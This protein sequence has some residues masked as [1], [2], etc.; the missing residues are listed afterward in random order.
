MR[1][2]VFSAAGELAY[3]AGRMAFD[4]GEHEAAWRDFRT[5]VHLADEAG[6]A[7]LAGHVLRAMAHQAVDLGQPSDRRLLGR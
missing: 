6:D 2:T 3:L 5:A 4:S 1:R 7:P